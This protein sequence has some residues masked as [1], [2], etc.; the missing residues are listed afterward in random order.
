MIQAQDYIYSKAA[1]SRM[2]KVAKNAVT[3]IEKWPVNSFDKCSVLFVI[4]KG[5]R[6]RFWKKLD[7]LCHFADWRRSQSKELV[8]DRLMPNVFATINKKKNSKYIVTI[9]PDSINCTCEDYKNQVKFL[10]KAGVCKHGYA[11][12][13]QLGLSK[14]SEYIKDNGYQQALDSYKKEHALKLTVNRLDAYSF[15]IQDFTNIYYCE[16][17][18]SIIKCSCSAYNPAILNSKQF[19]THSLAVLNYLGFTGNQQIKDYKLGFEWIIDDHMKEEPEIT[20]EQLRK[21]QEARECLFDY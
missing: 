19:C 18:P 17:H 9:K 6:P 20:A 11:V 10:S 13:K 2:L 4:V 3:R 8:V 7:F 21:E 12:L 15:A 16:L 14:F 5:R 1:V